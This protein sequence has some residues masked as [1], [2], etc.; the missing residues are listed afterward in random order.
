[1]VSLILAEKP[2]VAQD[3][4]KAL[5]AS[6]KDSACWENKQYRIISAIGHL[7]RLGD[8]EDMNSD[9]KVWRL[10][11]LPMIPSSWPLKVIDKTKKQFRLIQ[12]HLKS[13]DVTDIICATDA[14]REG[15]LIFRLILEKAACKKPVR[16]L[17]ISSLTRAA[18]LK[19]MERLRPG[20]EFDSLADS[21]RGR[22]R[23]DWLAGLNL[24]RLYSLISGETL[25][26]GRVQTPTLAILAKREDE[27]QNFKP[28]AYREVLA[29]FNLEETDFGPYP[30]GQPEDTNPLKETCY[31]GWYLVNPGLIPDQKSNPLINRRLPD[32]K[33]LT[34]AILTRLKNGQAKIADVRHKK[35]TIQAPR[36][37]DLTELQ[38]HANRLFRFSAQKTLS[39][40][41]SLYESHKLISY[42]RTDSRYLS[43]Q[44]A[45]QLPDIV[46]AIRKPYELL[47]APG[48]GQS[49]PGKNYVDSEKV[50]E[51]HAIIPTGLQPSQLSADEHK[52]FDLICRR[53]LGIWHKPYISSTT[54]L[55]T[56]VTQTDKPEP[57]DT[58][59]SKGT[60]VL[61][62]G[63]KILE[64]DL[65]SHNQPSEPKETL[66]PGL[67]P[68]TTVW[69]QSGKSRK[70]M[71]RP[72]LA[73]TEASLLTGMESAGSTLDDKNL[74]EAMKDKGLGTPATRAGIIETLKKRAYIRQDRNTLR[75]TEKGMQLIGRVHEDLKSPRLTGEWE[76]LL[77]KIRLGTY[78]L[79]EFMERISLWL[80]QQ[81]SQIQK[82][83]LTQTQELNASQ[84]QGSIDLK[85][86]SNQSIDQKHPVRKQ[87]AFEGQS[88]HQV[89]K[90]SF[91]LE[92]FRFQQQEV[93]ESLLNGKSCLLVMPTGAGKSLC[94]QLPG[95]MLRGVALVISPLI[96]LMED[97]V[98]S[99]NHLGIS[100]DCIHTGKSR[101]QSR[102][103][104]RRYFH[105][106]LKFLFVSP[107]RLGVP[108][109][110]A[111]LE[112]NPPCLIAIDEAH[113]ISQWGHDFRADYRQL[114]TRLSGL[115]GV[116]KIAL[117]AT[118]TKEVQQDILRELNLNDCQVFCSGF[119]RTNI[120]IH[121]T[122]MAPSERVTSMM[123]FLSDAANRPAIIYAPTRNESE[124]VASVLQKLFKV[125]AYHAGM[126]QEARNKIQKDF[127]D[128]RIEVMVATVA[129]GMGVNKQ[130]IRTVM[131]L[132]LPS[133]LSGY[134]Q[135]IGRSGR[136]GKLSTAI[137]FYS[138]ADHQTLT[139][140]QSWSYP[141]LPK[142]KSMLKK[143]GE[144]CHRDALTDSAH[145]EQTDMIL[146][147][148]MVHGAL[149]VSFDG[150]L[151]ATGDKG[152]S[153]RYTLQKSHKD[154]QIRDIW[155]FAQKKQPCR[156]LNLI[157]YFNHQEETDKPCGHCDLCQPEENLFHHFRKPTKPEVQYLNELW[158]FSAEKNFWSRG[159]LFKRV[160]QKLPLSKSHFD[161][162]LSSLL[163]AGYLDADWSEFQKGGRTIRYQQIQVPHPGVRKKPA[164]HW[165]DLR[166]SEAKSDL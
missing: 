125:R 165:R 17:W 8:P 112:Q 158:R 51:H 106:D 149:T 104:L 62:K 162:L 18:I 49:N 61:Q 150:L 74:S 153:K 103:A 154:Q 43:D 48:T 94:Y 77:E 66:P 142:L 55:L 56:T 101:E 40:A 147:K 45:A 135:E 107:E 121:V 151:T 141:E 155:E 39:L 46:D 32:D 128:G 58:Y 132:A 82:T 79:E 69:P 152:W 75:V 33:K 139:R 1:M 3:I 91:G 15:E 37:Y 71:T 68:E 102:D 12:G 67:T 123:G 6:R 20:D 160:S 11:S 157:D 131:H 133:G 136:D 14:G 2:S 90:Q 92:S 50:G 96:A 22:I 113:C 26:I 16:R 138:P 159:S 59:E 4:A 116:P 42:P 114:S 115:S 30:S 29:I 9:W 60:M 28:E 148:L 130:N 126:S 65:Q 72:P 27:I 140:L 36:L 19:G 156:M 70:A 122:E 118:A 144:S 73:L 7:V 23:A 24:S 143:I 5:N 63:W 54:T 52:I 83:P 80:S 89:L 109:F 164:P 146:Q 161:T 105:G 86:H 108:G 134:Y 166:I 110:T 13:K 163:D 100:A 111:W 85:H 10:S 41:Q 44:E 145:D 97:Q 137:L 57:V 47:L 64:D 120:K 25:S 95:L 87:H 93:C 81:V 127:M 99:L 117:T 53:L 129:F 21:A 78:S 88:I 35:T 119:R 84:P 76:A 38:R 34:D 98:A 124:R 31:K